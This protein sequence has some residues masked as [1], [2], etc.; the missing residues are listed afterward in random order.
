MSLDLALA[1]AGLSITFACALAAAINWV[2]A[3]VEHSIRAERENADRTY[4]RLVDLARLEGLM[5]SLAHQV[6]EIHRAIV[7]RPLT[8]E[9]H[10]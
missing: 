3:R 6:A 7:R 2:L 8:E 4:A 10:G 1:F 9:S 5:Q